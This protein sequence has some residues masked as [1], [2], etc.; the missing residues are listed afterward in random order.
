MRAVPPGEVLSTDRRRLAWRAGGFAVAALLL[1][2]TFLA[3]LQPDM[4]TAF[5]TAVLLCF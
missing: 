1:A 3:Y 2:V 4:L 5:A